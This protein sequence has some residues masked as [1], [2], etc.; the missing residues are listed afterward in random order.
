MN[1]RPLEPQGR[2]PLPGIALI[3]LG[4]L[5]LLPT[6]SDV[7]GRDL[8]PVFVFGPGL[9][10]LAMFFLDRREV[11]LLMPGTILT[12][13]GLLFLYCNIAGWQRMH[14]LWPLFLIAPGMGFILMFLL[15]NKER[16]LLIPG[17]ILTILGAIFL[18]GISETAY[19]VPAILI[20]TGLMF[21]VWPRR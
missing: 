11:G 14:D 2:S 18:T 17:G 19:L 5:L 9:F 12:V 8:W 15:G 20:L 6:V 4:G 21:L 10:F 1:N 3:I 7:H 13:I 16:G